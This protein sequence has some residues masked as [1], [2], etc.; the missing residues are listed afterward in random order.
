[1]PLHRGMRVLDLGCGRAASSVFLGREW[2]VQVWATD[3]WFSASENLQRIEDAGVQDNVF[4]IHADAHSLPFARGFFDAIISIDSFVYYGT[5]ELYLNYLMRFAKP[6]ALIGIVGAG[7]MAEIESSV[8]EHLRE[9]WE[10]SMW[11]LHSAAWWR[12][13]WEKTGLVSVEAADSMPDGWKAWL[14][15]QNAIAPDNIREIAAITADA[16][17]VLGYI[18]VVARRQ[19]NA[20]PEE[21]IT[22][23][24]TEYTKTPLLK[25]E[26]PGRPCDR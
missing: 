2:G 21:P 19:E 14:A 22:S 12:R 25:T 24:P 7:L 6:N 20:S 5:D 16:G 1:M 17:R 18:R 15:W 26:T 3:L 4:P 13:H 10:P 9:W 11:C 8:P 23:I